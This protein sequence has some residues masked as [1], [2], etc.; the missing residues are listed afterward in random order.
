MNKRQF[1]GVAALAGA[2]PVLG[3]QAAGAGPALLTVSGAISRPNRGPFNPALDQMM[4]KQNV[5]FERAFTLDYATLARLP[6]AAIEPTLEYD[7]RPHTCAGRCCSMCWA[8]PAPAR[9]TRRNW[10]C[11]R[12]MA[13]R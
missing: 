11:A 5:R 1:F 6:A 3:K 9:P 2:A 13:T 7:A 10:C 4:L 12:S 8:L